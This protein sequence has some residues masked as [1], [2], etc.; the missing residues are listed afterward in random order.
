[1]YHV[2]RLLW[3]RPAAAGVCLLAGFTGTVVGLVYAWGLVFDRIW[4]ILWF[5]GCLYFV[6][7]G[8]RERYLGIAPA[9]K[10]SE[11]VPAAAQSR[12]LEQKT[13]AELRGAHPGTDGGNP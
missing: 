9:R 3:N 7:A 6:G 10:G 8:L 1:M 5:C 12:T 4:F 11:S 2:E 13:V